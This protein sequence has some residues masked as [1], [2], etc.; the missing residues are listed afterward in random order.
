MRDLY[1]GT[2]AP[3][4]FDEVLARVDANQG[5]LDVG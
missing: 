4:T 5:N 1:Y 3:P 2:D